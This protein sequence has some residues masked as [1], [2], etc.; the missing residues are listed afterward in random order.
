MFIEHVLSTG[1]ESD[2]L[3]NAAFP[4]VTAMAFYVQECCNVFLDVVERLEDANNA[5]SA[6]DVDV[7]EAELV[8]KVF[9]LNEMLNISTKLDYSDEIGRRKMFAVMRKSSS[10]SSV[11]ATM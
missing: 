9:I 10:P 1:E 5:D 6:G 7:L 4:V 3:D 2:Q 11:F 8:D